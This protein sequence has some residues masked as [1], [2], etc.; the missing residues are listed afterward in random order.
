MLFEERADLSEAEA[1]GEDKDDDE[2]VD[3]K[4]EEEKSS[5]AND[6]ETDARGHSDEAKDMEGTFGPSGSAE[7][8]RRNEM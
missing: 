8:S 4:E 1:E 5:H 3:V 2:L 6:D 7:D